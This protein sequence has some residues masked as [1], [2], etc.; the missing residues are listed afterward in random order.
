ML[1]YKFIVFSV[2]LL[3]VQLGYGQELDTALVL[4]NLKLHLYN[5]VELG[6]LPKSAL[7]DYAERELNATFLKSKG[8]DNIIFFKISTQVLAVD[9]IKGSKKVVTYMTPVCF[10]NGE[11]CYFVYSYNR[12]N[13]RFNKLR[14]TNEN[15]FINLYND[16]QNTWMYWKPIKRIDKATIKQFNKDYWVDGLDLDCLL[17]S[18]TGKTGSCL[19]YFSPELIVD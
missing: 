15:D 14:G 11:E 7:R 4:K 3:N 13:N 10:K 17:R 5:E 12:K 2:L 16:L 9:T 8:F 18:L 19:D 1:K 6:L